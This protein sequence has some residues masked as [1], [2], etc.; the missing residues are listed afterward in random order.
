[1]AGAWKRKANSRKER[2]SEWSCPRQARVIRDPLHRIFDSTF[3]A[4]YR[5]N[6]GQASCHINVTVKLL[7]GG[8]GVRQL[9]R[10][11]ETSQTNISWARNRVRFKRD[12]LGAN[13]DQRRRRD[14]PVSDLFQVV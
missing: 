6:A 11:D 4:S 5:S 8:I 9:H 14:V 3:S 7:T 1:M 12:S 13:D 2:R 10:Y